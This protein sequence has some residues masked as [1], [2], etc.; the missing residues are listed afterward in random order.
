MPLCFLCCLLCKS[1]LLPSVE[2]G[3]KRFNAE[4]CIWLHHLDLEDDDDDDDEDLLFKFSSLPSV[5][6]I[7]QIKPR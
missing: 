1:S 7:I 5:P 6:I 2:R 4:R 3:S